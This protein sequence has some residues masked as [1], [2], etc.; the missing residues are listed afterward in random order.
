MNGWKHLFI[1]SKVKQ[2]PEKCVKAPC[3]IYVKYIV[4]AP[5]ET[6]PD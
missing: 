6:P 2:F 1:D 3:E 5:C 4:K